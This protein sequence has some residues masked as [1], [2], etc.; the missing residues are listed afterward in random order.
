MIT[1]WKVSYNDEVV[2]QVLTFLPKY[3]TTKIVNQLY[4]GSYQIQNVGYTRKKAEV[5]ILV[6][7]RKA[8]ESMEMAAAT[9]ALITLR[10]RDKIYRGYISESISWSAEIPGQYYSGSFTFL[11]DEV[12]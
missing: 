10:Y 7:S 9:A 5:T 1:D 6:E 3:E 8:Q 4:D 11:I 2:A 12:S